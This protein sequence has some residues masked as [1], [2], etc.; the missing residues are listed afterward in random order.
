M[1]IDDKASGSSLTDQV[2]IAEAEEFA[3]KLAQWRL[4]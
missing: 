4:G 2:S 1:V 3:Q